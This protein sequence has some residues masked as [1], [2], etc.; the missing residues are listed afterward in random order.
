[1][2]ES[3]G[4][5]DNVWF[6]GFCTGLVADASVFSPRRALQGCFLAAARAAA[7]EFRAPTAGTGGQSQIGNGYRP[8]VCILQDHDAKL[9]SLQPMRDREAKPLFGVI[10]LPVNHLL[11]GRANWNIAS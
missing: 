4:D 5:A 2:T 6:P 1:M 11:H 7:K 3:E 8:L 9:C 10:T